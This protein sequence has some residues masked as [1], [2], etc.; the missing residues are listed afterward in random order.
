[1]GPRLAL[2]PSALDILQ[3]MP[4]TTQIICL[5]LTQDGSHLYCTVLKG[6]QSTAAPLAAKAKA[7]KQGEMMLHCPMKIATAHSNLV[8]VVPGRCE[9]QYM[10]DS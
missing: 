7:G 4:P 6:Q 2:T 1:M 9:V 10:L 8:N 5:H 3:S